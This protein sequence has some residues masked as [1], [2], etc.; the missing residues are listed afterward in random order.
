MGNAASRGYTLTVISEKQLHE[1]L[2]RVYETD[3]LL[4]VEPYHRRVMYY[5]DEAVG[6]NIISAL[7]A[8]R[9]KEQINKHVQTLWAQ[10][11]EAIF[12]E[13]EDPAR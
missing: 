7:Q 1:A 11:H 5:L 9:H 12:A 8:A 3:D 4:A 13:R 6:Q 10:K 2:R